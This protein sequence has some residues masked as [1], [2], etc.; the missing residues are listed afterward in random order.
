[1]SVLFGAI[2]QL[3]FYTI[4]VQKQQV[5]LFGDYLDLVVFLVFEQ[6]DGYAFDA[7]LH[8]LT[9]VEEQRWERSRARNRKDAMVRVPQQQRQGGVLGIYFSFEQCLIERLHEL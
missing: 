7:R 2:V 4:R 8:D 3:V 6:P 9:V 1:M 5:V